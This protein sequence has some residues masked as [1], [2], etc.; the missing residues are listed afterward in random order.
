MRRDRL[1]ELPR[2]GSRCRARLTVARSTL[3]APN[4]R[5]TRAPS[6]SPTPLAPSIQ[7]RPSC[8]CTAPPPQAIPLPH[9]SSHPFQPRVRLAKDR[10]TT[11]AP[12]RAVAPAIQQAGEVSVDCEEFVLGHARRLENRAGR[13]LF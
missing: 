10:T 11:S 5:A 6:A 13:P 7:V 1:D 4:T 12:A 9:F 3:I 2:A 8:I